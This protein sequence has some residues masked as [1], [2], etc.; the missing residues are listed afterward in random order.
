MAGIDTTGGG[1]E[2]GSARWGKQK[3]GSRAQYG[4]MPRMVGSRGQLGAQSG[5]PETAG[6]EAKTGGVNGK[7]D[8]AKMLGWQ[9]KREAKAGSRNFSLR[10]DCGREPD[11]S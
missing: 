6:L 7:E 11:V 5:S 1:T 2:G 8:K 4:M 10:K 3:E 9:E